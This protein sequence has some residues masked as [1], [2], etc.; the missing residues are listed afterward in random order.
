MP[1]PGI[2]VGLNLGT[3]AGGAPLFSAGEI[4]LVDAYT[5]VVTFTRPVLASS[6]AT[7]ITIKKNTVSQTINSATRQANQAVVYFVLQDA[8][9][10][11][12]TLTF[13]YNAG[14]GD[15]SNLAATKI[16]AS[17][18]AV[19][20]VNNLGGSMAGYAMGVLCLTYAA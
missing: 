11:G 17:L 20:L 12:D 4:G 10:A 9:S 3:R 7:G 15:Y 16:M 13:E 8:A 19:S 1:Y 14:V 18:S 2:G 6:Y 5:V